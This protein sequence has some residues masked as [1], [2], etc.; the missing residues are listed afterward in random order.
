M[1]KIDHEA[2]VQMNYAM[3]R[4][5]CDIFRGLHFGREAIE[6]TCKVIARVGDPAWRC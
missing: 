6:S 3:G 1:N 5:V 2:L 4:L